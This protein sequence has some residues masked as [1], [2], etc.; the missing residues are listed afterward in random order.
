[1]YYP[2]KKEFIEL[3]R[4][5][6]L[7]PVYKEIIADMETPVS[8]FRKI[9]GKY[10]YLL[11]SVE[12][13]E[14]IGRYSFLGSNPILIIRSKGRKIEILSKGKKEILEGDPIDAL[15]KVMS[16]YRSVK[17]KGLPRFY[18]GLVG[19]LGYDIVR[20]LEKLPDKNPDDLKLPDMQFLLTDTILAFDRISHK[21]SI[22]SNVLIED[23]PIKAYETAINKIDLLEK[24]LT[25][26]V[27]EGAKFETGNE[28]E[29]KLS[30]NFTKKGFEAAVKKAKGHIESGD[31]IQVVLSQRFKTG[32]KGDTFRIYRILRTLNPSPYMYYLKFGDTSL[33]GTSPEVMVRLEDNVATIRPIAGTRRRGVDEEEDAQLEKELLADEKEKAEHIM[34]VDLGRNDL[35]RVCD[36]D[37]IK[38]NQLMA[39]EKY[40]HVMHIVSDISGRLNQ[41]KDAFDLMKASFPAGTVTGAP[42]V[43]AMEIIDELENLKR[44]PYAGA[45]GYF[46]FYGDLDTCITIRTILV[47]KD[48]AYVQAG[49]GIVADS[50]PAKE[51]EETL[52]KAKAMLKAVEMS[53][54]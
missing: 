20:H 36:F 49:A 29:L 10:S 25:G 35:G 24:K 47:N 27:K 43:R 4:K 2:S 16:R 22:I 6:N 9:E 54:G 7:I 51:Y 19:Y 17:I 3:S 39:I 13:G 40:S 15:K 37:T 52:N 8:A 42:K 12:G 23:D 46:S 18:G 31:V 32:I 41:G 14:K 34:L 53:Q 33:I 30:S 44:G 48:T 5:A 38:V 26:P 21:I 1:M 45:V 28:K 50:V 11:E